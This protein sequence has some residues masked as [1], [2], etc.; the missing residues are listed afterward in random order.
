MFCDRCGTQLQPGYNLCPKC[1]KVIGETLSFP[2]QSRLGR[3]LHTLGIL[4][5]VVGA[6]WL[7]PSI[8]LMTLGSVNL[9]HVL[10]RSS[11]VSW[12]CSIRR[13]ALLW[14]YTHSG[15]CWR[16]KVEAST[17]IWRGQHDLATEELFCS[18]Q[19]SSDTGIFS[20]NDANFNRCLHH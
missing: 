8:V 3:H 13:L 1:G 12:H 2:A 5:I 10:S 6:F 17:T 4:W 7:I 11:W 19:G 18:A 16:L 15:S 14:G 20:V 9:G